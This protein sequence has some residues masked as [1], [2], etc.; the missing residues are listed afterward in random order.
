MSCRG[1]WRPAQWRRTSKFIDGV[2]TPLGVHPSPQAAA[3][4]IARWL[5]EAGIAK[6]DAAADA[7]AAAAPET[8]EAAKAIAQAEKLVP[9]ERLRDHTKGTGFR[10]IYRKNPSGRK[11]GGF[12]MRL[13]AQLIAGAP[14]GYA[15][16]RMFNTIEEAVL[17]LARR[18][19]PGFDVALLT[20]PLQMDAG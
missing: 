1:S 12:E 8:M 4:A 7:A 11:K 19:G 16:T 18:L 15:N 6:L 17:G 9:L 10:S 14:A 3:L 5:G 13:D 20:A 2:Q